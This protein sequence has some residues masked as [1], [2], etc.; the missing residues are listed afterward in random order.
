MPDF[1]KHAG[2][3]FGPP[4]RK[5]DFKQFSLLDLSLEPPQLESQTDLG[6]LRTL[7]LDDKIEKA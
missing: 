2:H 7:K 4:E 1:R 3:F 5:L 6:M